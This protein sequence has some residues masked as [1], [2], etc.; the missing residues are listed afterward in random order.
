MSVVKFYAA[1]A[2]KNP[3]NVLEQSIGKYEKVLVLG[4]NPDDTRLDA[5]ASLN[6]SNM[7]MLW[8]IESFKNEILFSV[9]EGE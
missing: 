9:D 7:E 3:D 6:L 1:D 4:F 5:R 2:A 8:L